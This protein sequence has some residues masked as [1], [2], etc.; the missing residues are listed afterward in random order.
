[1][2]FANYNNLLNP[3]MLQ[4]VISIFTHLLLWL[5]TYLVDQTDQ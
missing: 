3:F 2:V 5:V 4:H 1:M